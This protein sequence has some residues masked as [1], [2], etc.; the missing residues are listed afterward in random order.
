MKLNEI[1]RQVVAF[2]NEEKE[3]VQ[4]KAAFLR[5]VTMDN[6][7]PCLKLLCFKEGMKIDTQMGD[8]NNVMQSALDP[9]SE[10]YAYQP[11]VIVIN[12]KLEILSEDL[13]YDFLGFERLK[14]YAHYCARAKR[15][16]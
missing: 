14:P 2:D 8:Y 13:F 15:A 3:W 10:L 5:N 7:V 12:L 9:V 6:I 11:D 16:Q 4:I 1:V